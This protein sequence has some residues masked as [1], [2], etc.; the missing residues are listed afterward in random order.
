MIKKPSRKTLIR[1]LDLICSQLVRARDKRCVLQSPRCNGVLQAGHLFTR[2]AYSTR[3]NLRNIWA[4]CAGHN[5]RHEYDSSV[6]QLWFIDRFGL[7]E[8]KELAREHHKVRKWS[9]PDLRELLEEYKHLLTR[10]R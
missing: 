6:F 1:Q 10:I 9:N 8:Y 2:A 5:L 4:Q 3:W 7:E